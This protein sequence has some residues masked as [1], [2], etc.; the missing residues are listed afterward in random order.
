MLVKF[1]GV[2]GSIPAP[3]TSGQIE[4]KIKLAF[5]AAAADQIDLADSE[6]VDE[7][8]ARLPVSIRGTVGGNTSCVSVETPEDLVIIDAGT[9]IRELGEALM[10]REFGQGQGEAAIF[11]THTHWDHIQ[12]FPFFRPLFVPGNRFK[13]YYLHSYAEQVLQEQMKAQWFPIQFN[14][15][16]AD[17][18]FERIEEGQTIHMGAM[19]ISSKAL[20]HPGK[21]YSYRVENGT[22][23]LVLAT[24]GEYKNLSA[25]HTKKYIDFF[26]GADVLVFDAMYS[27]RESI[28]REDWGHSSAL[29]GA[30]IARQAGVKRLVLFHQ[31]P[32]AEDDEVWRVYGE[33]REYMS[34]DLGNALPE[35]LVATEGLEIDLSDTSDFGVTT[36]QVG[37]VAILSLQGRFDAYGAELFTNQFDQL[38]R[39]NDRSRI[40]L[41]MQD[42]TELNM[43]GVKALLDARTQTYSLA[44]VNL[45]GHVR[46]V[47]ELAVTIDFFAIYDDLDMALEALSISGNN[48]YETA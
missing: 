44:L 46:R 4:N 33:T 32:A 43:A 11:F 3:I 42:V 40:V 41:S 29:I 12:G 13:V 20:Q 45:P 36:Q 37:N 47:L 7:F 27:V 39:Q 6:A 21:A 38:L 30:D 24:D 1:W 19:T 10:Q 35:V 14:R 31:D 34:Q 23:T 28:I 16:E 18:Q 48:H 25:T 2:R 26:A 22:S 17:V 9:G 8:V 15:V 5:Q